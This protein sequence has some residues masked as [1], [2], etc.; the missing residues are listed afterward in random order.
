MS[1]MN[2]FSTKAFCIPGPQRCSH[3]LGSNLRIPWYGGM[4]DILHC[5]AVQLTIDSPPHNIDSPLIHHQYCQR[6]EGG[7][8]ATCFFS[9]KKSHFSMTGFYF[10][11][12]SRI[13]ICAFLKQISTVSLY[14][15]SSKC[16]INRPGVA[17]AVL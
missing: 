4:C 3:E 7:E 5:R 8:N 1:E 11:V 15:E 12:L 9:N 6:Q 16:I 17:G 10:N 2:R 13:N 14:E